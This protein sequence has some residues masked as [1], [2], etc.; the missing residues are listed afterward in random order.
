[1]QPMTIGRLLKIATASIVFTLIA[2]AAV[3]SLASDK[4]AAKP[5][6]YT[7]VGSDELRIVEVGG[8][9][10]SIP[11]RY[12]WGSFGT[13]SGKARGLNLIVL[14]PDFLPYSTEL[15]EEFIDCIG[16]CRQLHLSIDE[17]I[18]SGHRQQF[19][20]ELSQWK[21]QEPLDIEAAKRSYSGLQYL[22][23]TNKKNT[24]EWG[25]FVDEGF[26][27]QCSPLSTPKPSCTIYAV[28][29]DKLEIRMAFSKN[30]LP[31]IHAIVSRAR[32]FVSGH[33]V[34][35]PNE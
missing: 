28:F 29:D 11:R 19:I 8:R 23:L 31:N 3:S 27:Y 9:K 10:L 33:I 7:F 17:S 15:K 4:A 12:F 6:Q 20:K 24:S 35:Q 32:G 34:K 22:V 25:L 1:M 21:R 16:W 18:A 5:R 26:Y 14:L 2:S 13:T 30:H